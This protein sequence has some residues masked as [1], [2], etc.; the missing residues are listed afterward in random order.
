MGR[1]RQ[2]NK[3]ELE[4]A[5]EIEMPTTK[6]ER[7]YLQEMTLS[8]ARLWFR[9]RCRIIEYIKEIDHLS[10]EIWNAECRHCTTGDSEK[11]TFFSTYRD[12]LDLTTRIHK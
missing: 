12:G 8:D 6:I 2:R 11:C 1:K 5:K 7:N 9:Y 3:I 10:G 4:K